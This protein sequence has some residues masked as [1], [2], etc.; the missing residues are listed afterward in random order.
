[1]PGG[2]DGY[3]F[4]ERYDAAVREIARA[5]RPEDTV[6]AVSH[7]AAIRTYSALRAAGLDPH[8]VS[9]RRIANTGAVV[10]DGHPDEGWRLV[11]WAGEPLG[12]IGLAGQAAHDVTGQAPA[13]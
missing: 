12:G 13:R 5:G 10:L 9:R 2:T 8:D 6:V 7:G 4:L 1:M 3:A 11:R